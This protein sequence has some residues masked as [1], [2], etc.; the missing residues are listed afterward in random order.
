VTDADLSDA[1]FPFRTA[2]QISIGF[3]VVTCVRIT[4]VG[5]LGY[6]LYVP[7]EQAVHVYDT[8][9]AADKKHG[10]GL[11]HVGLRALG[12][13]R[14]EKAYR[15]YGHDMDNTDSIIEAGLGFTCD[16]TKVS[17]RALCCVGPFAVFM[18]GGGCLGIILFPPLC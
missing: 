15:D 16:F 14:M 13:L 17:W 12:S 2:R 10:V 9:L 18:Y 1:A 5:E 8:I 3:A 4:Y 11:V 7:V 6:E